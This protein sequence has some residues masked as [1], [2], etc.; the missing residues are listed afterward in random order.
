MKNN[1]HFFFA[2]ALIILFHSN[3]VSSAPPANSNNS[4]FYYQIGGAR[5]ISLPAN[6]S[7]KTVILDA[8]FEYGL[9]Y[10]CGN[11]N[12]LKGISDQLNSLKGIKDKLIIGAV[13]AVTS[14]IS[15][16]PALILQRINPGLYDLFQNAL[17]RAEATISLATKAC[18]DYE[19]EI[20]QGKNPYKGW[21]NISKGIDWK[22][23]MGIGGPNS[24][25]VGVHTAKKNVAKN[26]GA[27]GLPWINGKKAG[28][29]N[30]PPIKATAD[31]VKAGYN[32]TLNRKAGETKPP[33][34]KKGEVKRLVEVFKTPKEASDFAVDV[35]GDVYARTY[36]NSKSQTIPGHGLLPKIQTENEAVE[37]KMVDLV[38][39]AAKMTQEKL[40]EISSN[41]VMITADVIQAMQR[42]HPS[43]R[44]IAIGKLSSEVAMSNVMEKALLTRR[45]LIT[46]RREP[47]ISQTPANQHAAESIA[48]LDRDIENVM[49]EKRIHTELAS[50]T[51]ALILE[52]EAQ[53]VNRGLA[54]Q[55]PQ[56][57]ENKVIEDG[58]IK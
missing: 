55:N 31:V 57:S 15:S 37:K 53:H 20:R 32:L 38:S 13:G 3:G 28:G 46:G 19:E 27:G 1:R 43:E 44:A 36:G 11:F 35:I 30:Q 56:G 26:N 17:I 9:G 45:M 41:D 42:M 52:L 21:K 51:P 4:A 7:V 49:F 16:L 33:V 5:S 50:N 34:I 58:A 24:S 47:N 23:Q 39:G 54:H 6:A 12:P 22:I 29:L 14:A 48:L 40:A 18:E 10:S 25:S 8:S 2:L